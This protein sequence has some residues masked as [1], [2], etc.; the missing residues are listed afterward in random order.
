MKIATITLALLILILPP[1]CSKKETEN[2]GSPTLS[3][4]DQGHKKAATHLLTTAPRDVS[5]PTAP[6]PKKLP[7]HI[8]KIA[9]ACKEGTPT[10]CRMLST[11]FLKGVGV[12]KNRSMTQKYSKLAKTAYTTIL[13][14]WELACKNG[15]PSACMSAAI[16]YRDAL[17]TPRDAK[18]SIT[19]FH[20][21][22]Q[23]YERR[24]TQKSDAPACYSAAR[25]YQLGLMAVRELA[26]DKRFKKVAAK[27]ITEKY[28]RGCTL[29]NADCCGALADLARTGRFMK[30]DLKKARALYK[31][32]CELA[33]TAHVKKR[34]CTF[35]AM[36][37]LPVPRKRRL[38][39]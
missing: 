10:S 32:G 38:P 4:P 3:P 1:A 31:K 19:L 21:S 28:D 22:A 12:A 6:P 14:K 34:L 27:Y 39:R 2:K 24:C 33:V 26:I 25:V 16:S 35:A 9:K 13:P 18:K 37:K 20:A 5:P 15:D 8:Q 36:K 23:T 11:L 29:K 7:P 30:R 17:G